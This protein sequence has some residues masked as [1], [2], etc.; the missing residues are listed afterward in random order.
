MLLT[1]PVQLALVVGIPTFAAP[2]IILVVTRLL[3]RGDKKRAQER[4][5]AVRKQVEE[6][7]RLLRISTDAAEKNAKEIKV[8]VKA[9]HT[10][11]NSDK[12]VAIETNLTA[13]EGQLAALIRLEKVGFRLNPPIEAT[14]DELATVEKIRAQCVQLRSELADRAKQA[15]IVEDQLGEAQKNGATRA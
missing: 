8:Q 3:D 9:V 1:E 4:E 10:L 7:A 13:L 12:T 6:A 14:I 11:V 15:K 2:I 5:D